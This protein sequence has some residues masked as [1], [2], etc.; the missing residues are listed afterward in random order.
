VTTT[1][2]VAFT[3]TGTDADGDTLTYSWNFGDGTA[4]STQQNP[5]HTYA[6][7]GTYSAVVTVS[8]G[9]GGTA[10]STQSV[11]V[12]AVQGNQPP[13]I[14]TGSATPSSGAA[15]LSVAFSVA[16]TDPD[17]D[18]L[19]YSWNFGDATAAST[20]QNPTHSYTTAGSYTATVTVSDGKG[21]TVSRSFPVSVISTSTTTPGD[22]GADV[23]FVLGLTLGTPA[24]FGTIT[25]GQTKD[26]TT[27]MSATVTS[28][29]G[30][31]TLSVADPDTTRTGKLVNGTYV[32]AS[33]LQIM[34]TNG[35]HP[36]GAFAPVTGT[37]SPLN[38]LAYPRAISL[39][40]VVIGFKQ[41]VADT[42]VLRAGTY[43]K[44]LTFTLSTV[45]P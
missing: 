42:E 43:S 10:T 20:Q 16:A 40:P 8:D 6:T 24:T 36:T 25:P 19:T 39:D 13:T 34:A 45:T 35:A 5:S 3:A 1:T 28:T 15:P 33:P 27:T 37:A 38:L 12:Q 30:D 26:Y 14:T 31:A 44:T 41:S 23:P 4:A 7:A 11:V 29:A 21:G 9:K 2:P 18:T 17:S 32:L 22:V